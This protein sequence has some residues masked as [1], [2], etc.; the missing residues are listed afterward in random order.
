MPV[1]NNYNPA[2]LAPK[3]YGLL[4]LWIASP[5]FFTAS[6]G[7]LTPGTG[8]SAGN[9]ATLI[10]L[11]IATD[12]LEITP[13]PFYNDIYS[14]QYGGQQ[15]PPVD[16]QYLGE[17]IDI[18]FS[19]TT[20][21][22]V[23]I[24]LLKRRAINAVRG[25]VN[26]NEI[27]NFVLRSHSLRFLINTADTDDI[28]NFWCCLARQPVPIGMGTKW[29][30]YRISLTAYRPPCYH[31]MSGVIE[32]RSLVGLPSNPSGGL[33]ADNPGTGSGGLPPSSVIIP[34]DSTVPDESEGSEEE[35]P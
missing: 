35:D 12:T 13:R 29:A 23:A 4:D 8:G 28:R 2:C 30:E 16:V 17:T 20:W 26:Q 15:G 11:G 19:L 22:E 27:G 6:G 7:T 1:N 18:N 5:A 9:P 3:A 34:D 24:N 10:R 31:P 33:P 32:D 25:Q 21:N 14:D